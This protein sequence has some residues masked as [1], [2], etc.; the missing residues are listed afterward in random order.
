MSRNQ[1]L[2]NISR[3]E[4]EKRNQYGWLVRVMRDG[5]HHQKFFYDSVHGSKSSS[6]LTAIAYRDELLRKYPKPERGNLFNRLT[7]RNKS[8]YPGVNKTR[9]LKRGIYYDVWQASWT[10][11][12]G[13]TVNRRFYFSPEGR[14]EQEAKELAIKARAEGLKMI[15][16]MMRGAIKKSAS[17]RAS[18][19]QSLAPNSASPVR[20][21]KP[22]RPARNRVVVR[23]RDRNDA[24][25]PASDRATHKRER[26]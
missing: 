15:K 24:P 17:K 16:R 8:E 22:A 13:K 26:D 18:K 5:V 9:T 6:L 3:V 1:K 20:A 21:A 7:V 4:Q 2:K 11:P 19:K 10:L 14:T 23:A 25:H 12:N